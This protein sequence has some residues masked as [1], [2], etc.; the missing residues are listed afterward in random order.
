MH[1]SEMTTKVLHVD[2]GQGNHNVIVAGLHVLLK[3]DGDG[4]HAQGLQIDYAA[5]GATVEDA[6]EAFVSGFLATIRAY[7]KR[8]G[9]LERLL[10]RQAPPE[11]FQQYYSNSSGAVLACGTQ[12]L[13]DADQLPPSLRTIAFV[14]AEHAAAA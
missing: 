7:L 4:W 10:K 6:K 5:S 9:S 8:F 11:Y 13:A 2:D 1:T 3:P 14:K 12:H